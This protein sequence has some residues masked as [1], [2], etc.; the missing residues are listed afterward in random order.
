MSA[1]PSIHP[2]T[3]RGEV[4][5][6]VAARS[7]LTCGR[8]LW[9]WKRRLFGAG[10]RSSSAAD[11]CPRPGYR[12]GEERCKT[13]AGPENQGACWETAC[14]LCPPQ[15]YFDDWQ[16]F[17]SFLPHTVDRK[18]GF[19]LPPPQ[20]CVPSQS[21]TEPLHLNTSACFASKLMELLNVSMFRSSRSVWRAVA[22][23]PGGGEV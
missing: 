2:S 9:R 18:K 15:F 20:T 5:T 8:L 10:W 12:W 17:F 7:A 6:G 22:S 19:L 4:G 13:K 3:R 11:A 14:T 21:P 23:Q 16:W 1:P